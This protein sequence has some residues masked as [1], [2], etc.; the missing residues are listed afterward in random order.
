MTDDLPRFAPVVDARP[1][2]D[3]WPAMTWPPEPGIELVASVVT[4]RL[5][6]PQQDARALF[7]ALDDD[8]VWTHMPGRPDGPEALAA[9]LTARIA[10][11]WHPWLVRLRADRHGLEAGAVV[12]MSSYLDV[13]QPDARLEIGST[14]YAPAVWAG[15]VNPETKLL[16]L[17][18]AFDTLGAGRVQ[19]KTDVRNTRS[20][21]AIARLGATYEG[22]LRR[23]QRRADGSVRDTA[24]FSI[25]AE[26]WPEVR[27]RLKARLC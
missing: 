27:N 13:H 22:T 15:A 8:R 26:Q 18:N 12:G 2:D 14:L 23:Y 6:R 24:L 25:T 9:D 19:L 5:I 1:T 17:G 3:R 4:V 20:Q 16:L 11:G 7:T 10:D 21:Q